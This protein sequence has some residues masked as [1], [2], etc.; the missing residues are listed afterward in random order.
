M[1]QVSKAPEAR[2]MVTRPC[3]GLYLEGAPVVDW[4][5][6]ESRY[7]GKPQFVV[8]L[9][10][11]VLQ[12]HEAT[13]ENLRAAVRAEDFPRIVLIS[14]GVKSSAGNLFADG[15]RVRALRAEHLA[16]D[17][18][19]SGLAEAELLAGDVEHWLGAVQRRMALPMFGSS[20]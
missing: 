3:D 20:Q 4:V 15:L 1:G 6:L 5:S 19:P 8:R 17:N 2:P 9:L 18:D 10:K 14:H 16:R 13:A 7:G 11:T 12:V